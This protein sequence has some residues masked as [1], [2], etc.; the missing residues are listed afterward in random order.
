MKIRRLASSFFVLSII[1]VTCLAQSARSS[2]AQVDTLMKQEMSARH[3]PGASVAVVSHGAV[4]L[5]KGYGLADVENQVPATPDTVYEIASLTKQF[6]ATAVM[7]PVAIAR[8][9][10][11]M[12]HNAEPIS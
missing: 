8:C 10:D 5:L 4:V 2:E 6:T 12:N 9:T 3:I 1:S 7:M 11:S